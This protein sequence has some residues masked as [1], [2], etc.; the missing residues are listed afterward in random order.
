MEGEIRENQ[1]SSSAM[2]FI[3][4]EQKASSKEDIDVVKRAASQFRE[5]EHEDHA[6]NDSHSEIVANYQ[7]RCENVSNLS[8][9]TL[10]PNNRKIYFRQSL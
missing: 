8:A 2:N 7:Y 3:G 9:I 4:F 1:L 6:Q 10:T 5:H